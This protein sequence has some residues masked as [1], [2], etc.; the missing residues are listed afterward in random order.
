MQTV[1]TQQAGKTYPWRWRH[2]KL[3]M[4]LNHTSKTENFKNMT[5]CYVTSTHLHHQPCKF[6][7]NVHAVS[8]H[9]QNRYCPIQQADASNR[10]FLVGLKFTAYT[11]LVLCKRLK[12]NLSYESRIHTSEHSTK[13]NPVA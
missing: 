5:I 3:A 7:N 11:Y 1:Q 13:S 10:I 4:D 2:I 9:S 8:L 12:S 6:E